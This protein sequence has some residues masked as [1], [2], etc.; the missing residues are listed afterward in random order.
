MSREEGERQQARAA[1]PIHAMLSQALVA[2]TI[3]AD[4][5]FGLRMADM[6]N[7]GARL[8]LFAWFNALRFLADAPATVREL[9]RQAIAPSNGMCARV[10]C[11]ERWRFVSPGPHSDAS[12]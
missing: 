7:P 11:L 6:G 8:S 12:R 5:A 9:E 2:Y 4:N 10:A 3:E 1:R